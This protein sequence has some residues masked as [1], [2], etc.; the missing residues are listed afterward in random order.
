MARMGWCPS[1]RLFE[2][3]ACAAPI[4]SDCWDGIED[5]FAP[6]SEILLG[7]AASDVIN[8]LDLEDAQ[9]A[10]IAR[11]GRERTLDQH[12]S[13]HRAAELVTALERASPTAA[14]QLAEA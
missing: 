13:Q 11:A 7:R 9:L 12:T 1:G 3:A 6:G 10:R 4:L 5:F 8:A 2:A 14:S